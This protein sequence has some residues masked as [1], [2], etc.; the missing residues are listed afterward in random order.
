MTKMTDVDPY[1]MTKSD[2]QD[3]LDDMRRY[4]IRRIATLRGGFS[5]PL[6]SDGIY[7]AGVIGYK[8]R[9]KQIFLL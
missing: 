6:R 9:S 1:R 3:P 4:A 5:A 7:W 2:G 8:A